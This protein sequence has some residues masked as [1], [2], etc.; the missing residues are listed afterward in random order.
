MHEEK[1]V[2]AVLFLSLDSLCDCRDAL[3]VPSV[4][5]EG[6]EP[7]V[8]SLFRTDLGAHFFNGLKCECRFGHF[9]SER[10]E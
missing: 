7:S 2:S 9:Y 3:W 1:I 4:L 10:S 6:F 8:S 5:S